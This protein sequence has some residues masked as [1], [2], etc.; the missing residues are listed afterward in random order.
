MTDYSNSKGSSDQEVGTG[1]MPKTE[2]LDLDV[3]SGSGTMFSRHIGDNVASSSGSNI[4]S[5]FIG[6]GFSSSLVDKVIY[7]K[8]EDDVDLLL[9]T[10][11]TYSA[12]EKANSESSDSLDGLFSDIKDETSPPEF[13]AESHPEEALKKTESSNSLDALFGDKKDGSSTQKFVADVHPKEEPDVYNQRNGDKRASLLMMNFSVGEVKFAMDKLGEDASVNE[14]VDFI[15][16]AQ[17]AKSSEKDAGN[18][19]SREKNEDDNNEALFGTMEKTLR[20]LE[21]GFS[22]NEISAAIEKFGS[23]VPISELADSIFAGQFSDACVEENKCSGLGWGMEP[24]LKRH[25]DMFEVKA[26]EYS[27]NDASHLRYTD[28]DRHRKGKR[29]KNEYYDDSSTFLGPVSWLEDRK[30]DLKAASCWMPPPQRGLHRD[31]FVM[32]KLSSNNLGSSL[33]KI[34]AKPPYFIYG[35]VVNVSSS[36]WAK[37][38]QFLHVREPEFVNTQFFSALS[39]KEGYVH[40]L[41]TE[42]R[43]H[44]LPKPPMTIEDAIPHTKKWWPSWDTRKQLNC[45]TSETTGISQLCD[46]LGRIL[47]DSRGLLSIEKQ[48]D[49]LHHCWKWNL[50]W[51][52]QYKLTPIEPE[53]LECILGYPLHHTR[54][55]E[56]S[57]MERL[58]SLKH[59]F[60]TDTLGYHLSVLKPI[61]PGGLAILSL[62]SGIGGAEVSLHRLGIHLRGVVSVETS[63]AKRRILQRWWHNSGQT[64]ELVQIEDVHRL[65]TSKLESFMKKFGGFDLIVCQN[66]CTSSS[67]GSKMAVDSDT[68][69]GFDFTL[70]CE[71]VRVLQGVRSIMERQQ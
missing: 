23:E 4:R 3:P 18:P 25:F 63:E 16:A 1:I 56:F 40:N 51:V 29:P 21:M 10:L 2:V 26:E 52:G 69:A 8:G 27:L 38:S 71:F 30:P 31:R 48:K 36:S 32:D 70:F 43:F 17:I 7:E 19:D 46:R 39:R 44:I 47:T 65:S 61:F 41:P 35:N 22:E 28:L 60:Q 12:L 11:F 54:G 9:E 49:I 53:H 15:I 20:L 6:M 58:E 24:G 37:I 45:L 62:F 57:F 68:L 14:L 50:V 5:S 34:A 42:S 64:G 67:K 33:D 13:T 55:P 59:C 66:P